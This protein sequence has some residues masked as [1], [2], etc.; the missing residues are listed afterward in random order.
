M[1]NTIP[2]WPRRV[3]LNGRCLI[4]TEVLSNT[5]GNYIFNSGNHAGEGQNVGYADDHVAWATNPYVGTNQDNIFT[6]MGTNTTIATA[7]GGTCISSGAGNAA[8]AT[9]GETSAPSIAPYDIFMEPARDVSSGN[10]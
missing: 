9:Q 3:I 5:Y 2:R 4:P 8:T 6:F 7:G 10:W 1:F